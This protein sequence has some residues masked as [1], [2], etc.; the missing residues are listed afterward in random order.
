[1]GEANRNKPLMVFDWN[2][3]A[4]LIK[5]RNPQKA[6]AG[7]RSDWEWTG[8]DIYKDGQPCLDDYTF[9]SST[10]ATPEI[11]IDG[12]VIAC[13]IYQKDSDNWNSDTKWPES[14]LN[15]LKN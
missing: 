10:W 1:M 5:E 7:L 9:L 12:E 11:E 3:A 13:W 14:A 8:G 4:K 2:T 6:S 15:I